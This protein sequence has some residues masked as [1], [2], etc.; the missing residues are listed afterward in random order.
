MPED[1]DNHEQL[2]IL[3]RMLITQTKLHAWTTPMQKDLLPVK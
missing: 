3:N 2:E 1:F